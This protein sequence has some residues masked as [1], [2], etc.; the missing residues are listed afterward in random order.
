MTRGSYLL[1]FGLA[2]V[3]AGF[4]ETGT[5]SYFSPAFEGASA[6]RSGASSEQ[7]WIVSAI[8]GS[9]LNIA[10]YAGHFDVAD[11]F[12]ARNIGT[13]ANGTLRF[14]L[15]R[16]AEE[17]TIT[18]ARPWTPAAYV[19][20]ARSL[21]A[22]GAGL[23]VTEDLTADHVDGADS[24]AISRLLQAHPRSAAVHER[25]ALLIG[26]AVQNRAA[27]SPEY[28]ARPAL[29][30]MT[31]HLAMA[32]ALHPGGPTR[33]GRAAEQLLSTLA[34]SQPEHTALPAAVEHAEFWIIEQ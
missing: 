32:L 33:D 14:R 20:V 8:A 25:A 4:A 30:R 21:M 11:P 10:A 1:A 16:R 5:L 19:R 28:D 3:T 31:A 23:S 12:Q 13:D 34:A 9:M 15:T 24:Q 6:A 18:T 22:D 17:Y 26:Q 7:E 29:C 2:L 27:A